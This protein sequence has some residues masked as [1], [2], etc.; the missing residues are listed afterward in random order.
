MQRTTPSI[1]FSLLASFLPIASGCDNSNSNHHS[2]ASAKQPPATPS[3]VAS[4]KAPPLK[5]RLERCKSTVETTSS[6]L[7]TVKSTL[8][9]LR[10]ELNQLKETPKARYRAIVAL[11]ESVTD[12]QG[13]DKIYSAI[14]KFRKTFPTAKET[15]LVLRVRSE[16]R[17][18][19]AK[20]LTAEKKQQLLESI[21]SIRAILNGVSDG[22]DLSLPQIIRLG[23]ELKSN[24]TRY[25]ELRKLP[26]TKW[27]DAMKDP[28]SERGKSISIYGKIIQISRDGD[29]FKGLICTENQYGW[30]D[31]FYYFVTPGTTKG[32]NEDSKASFAG[33]FVQR[34]SY[35]TTGGGQK[36]SL[37]LV[38]YFDRQK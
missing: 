30:C 9:K 33:V 35:K 8:E 10:T 29:Y 26:K 4:E 28:D 21:K 24:E 27:D 6:E 34:Y 15:S 13:V 38:G 18:K 31:N 11:A 23:Q 25:V 17:R 22:T 5:E 19:R 1:T 3:G 12:T 16:L 2:T 14:D 20:F 32:I 36:H 37:A 7:R